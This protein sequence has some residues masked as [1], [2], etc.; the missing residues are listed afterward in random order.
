MT[1]LLAALLLAIAPLASAR[2]TLSGVVRAEGGAAAEGATVRLP[3]L[4]RGILTDANGFFV[5][6]SVPAG[7]WR[8]EVTAIGYAPLARVVE[9]R[10]EGARSLDLLLTPAPVELAGVSV[11]VE[12]ERPAAGGVGPGAV[13]LEPEIIRTLPSLIEADVFR[14]LQL[15]PAVQAS[16]D[17]SSALYVRGGSPDQNL[18]LLDGAPVFNPYHLGGVFSAF[19]PSATAGVEILPGAFPAALGDRL[20][21]VVDVRTRNGRREGVRGSGGVGLVSSRVGLEGPLPGGN[22]GWLLSLRRT[23]LDL[24]TDAAYA[25]GLIGGT[26]P[27]HFTD[28]HLKLDHD[29]G[30]LGRLSVSA[31]LDTEWFGLP[32]S[33]LSD[34]DGSGIERYSATDAQF[35]W[36]SRLVAATWWQPLAPSLVAEARIGVSAFDGDFFA[37]ER[38]FRDPATGVPLDSLR[39]FLDAG[40]RMRDVYAG[41][42][43][44]G[45]RGRH[46]LRTGAQVDRYSLAHHLREPERDLEGFLPEFDRAEML[47][48]V[49]LYVEDEW[50]PSDALAV[51]GGLRW[52]GAGQR[53]SA[54][55]PR[56]GARLEVGDRLTLSAG[57]GLYAQAIQSLRS[58]EAAFSS[59]VAYD[60]VA[61]VPDDGAGLSRAR[62]IAVGAEWQRTGTRVRADAYV[63]WLSELPL[64]PLPGDVLEAPILVHDGFVRAAGL[65]RGLELFAQHA[66]G[67]TTFTGSW[68]LTATRLRLDGTDYT[69][70]YQRAHTLDLMATRPLGERGEASLRVS[71]GSGQPYTPVIGV[72]SV[73]PYDLRS[74]GFLRY[75]TRHAVLGDYNAASLPAYFRMDVGARRE[76]RPR[77]FGREVS[78]TPYLNILNVL[79]TPNALFAIPEAYGAEGTEVEYPPQIPFFPTFGVD[80]R[81]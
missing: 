60:M 25:L 52:L 29:V 75:P 47:T 28:G 39:T 30:R 1:P 17:F 81:F 78:V 73:H 4:G 37:G 13:T 57:G 6:P 56:V 34:D 18:L 61:A 16:S 45:Y 23:Y 41:T 51:R 55:M 64:P 38:Y 76:L 7:S 63:K 69:P 44:T 46:T 70:R 9:V 62:D 54:L 21:S 77:W 59:L 58:E 15:L 80:W 3:E 66:R 40:S 20:S 71:W 79:N 53:G 24:F 65:A 26:V 5:L 68:A 31:Y 32:E 22:G 33:E 12:A 11:E 19:D 42:D 36:G 49:A 8:L 50:A 27:Y 74:G 14:A 35:H 2:P 72:T 10:E 43:L 48:T 67:R